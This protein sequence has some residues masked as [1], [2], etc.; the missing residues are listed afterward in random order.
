MD[1]PVRGT[2]PP[3]ARAPGARLAAL[4]IRY[5]YLVCLGALVLSALCAVP[6]LDLI[7][8]HVKTN[9]F[10]L[11]PADH[12][13][14]RNLTALIDKTNGWGD[15]MVVIDS[16]D[17]AAN[18]R[19]AEALQASLADLRWINY[20]ECRI[21]TGFLEANA[22]LL[23]SAADLRTIE[24][25][26]RDRFDYEVSRRDPMYV[27]LLEEEPP[28][29]DFV[30]IEARYRRSA[31]LRAYH[32]SPDGRT[33]VLAIYPAGLSGEVRESRGYLRE[34]QAKVAAIG[35]PDVPGDLKVR[36]GG[37]FVDRL[38]EYDSIV[39]D[40]AVSAAIMAALFVALLLWHFRQAWTVPLVFL[41]F[42]MPLLWTF[43]LTK[44]VVAELNLITVFLVNVLSG[45]GIDFAIHVL[46]RYL[47]ERSRGRSLHEALA[48]VNSRTARACWSAA[49]TTAVAFWVLLATRFLG[50][51]Q[52][53]IIAGFGLTFA[54]LCA[55]LVLPSLIAIAEDYRLLQSVQ[56]RDLPFPL[57]IRPSRALFAAAGIAAV[58]GVA[59]ATQ[60]EFEHDLSRLKTR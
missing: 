7:R 24:Q 25:R 17:P 38:E 37:T 27:D 48:I 39:R 46:T 45:L 34:L 47:E 41:T 55:H 12:S 10:S 2:A 11:L 56:A 31:L 36:I 51:R 13:S 26:L 49:M 32:S 8:L 35:R 43:A 57:R 54:F 33:L 22:L 23:I 50:F 53:G 42:G 58:L 16:P 28:P 19:Y 14:V 5:R 21:D 60:L 44:L 6:A 40:L 59:G 30:D 9:I 20:G 4:S 3:H 52:F 15:L 29:V 1:S 18:V